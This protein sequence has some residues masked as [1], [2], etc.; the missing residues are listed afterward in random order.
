MQTVMMKSMF[1]RYAA[2][3]SNVSGFLAI[4]SRA[5]EIQAARFELRALGPRREM[6]RARQRPRPSKWRAHGRA[7]LQLPSYGEEIMCESHTIDMLKQA[8]QDWL[9]VQSGNRAQQPA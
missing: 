2:V 3:S 4:G 6:N 7:T 5:C 1:L 8:Q 9:D